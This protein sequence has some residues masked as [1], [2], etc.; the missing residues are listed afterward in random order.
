MQKRCRCLEL[1]ISVLLILVAQPALGN[2]RHISYEDESDVHLRT[3]SVSWSTPH[4]RSARN[5]NDSI[6]DDADRDKKTK[7]EKAFW[8]ADPRQA[9]D[10]CRKA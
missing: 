4:K 2:H 3:R 1:L 7:I 9:T 6:S 10:S 5:Q 8:A